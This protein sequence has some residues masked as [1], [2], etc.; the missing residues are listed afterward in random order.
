MYAYSISHKGARLTSDGEYHIRRESRTSS[1]CMAFESFSDNQKWI[2]VSYNLRIFVD[3]LTSCLHIITIQAVKDFFA[4]SYELDIQP[5]IGKF[6]KTT[7]FNRLMEAF[8]VMSK[9]IH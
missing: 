6:Y 9:Y 8:E 4:L 2:N 3:P 7:K 5:S 1:K